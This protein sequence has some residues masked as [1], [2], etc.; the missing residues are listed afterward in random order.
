MRRRKLP[1]GDYALLDNERLVATVERKTFD[2]LLG[3]IGSIQ[4]LHHHLSQLSSQAGPVL[5]IEAQYGDFLN[6]KR[7]RGRWPAAHTSPGAGRALPHGPAP[8]PSS[9]PMTQRLPGSSSSASRKW[10]MAEVLSPAVWC[11]SPR[12]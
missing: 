10:A 9:L 5:V 6:E 8:S 2:N 1:V 4:A 12:A 7:L 3:D 11:S